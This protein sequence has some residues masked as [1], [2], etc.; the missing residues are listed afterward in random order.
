MAPAWWT[1]LEVRLKGVERGT[2]L[3]DTVKKLHD[4]KIFVPNLLKQLFT[5]E[6]CRDCPP[7]PAQSPQEH[8]HKAELEASYGD[9][10]IAASIFLFNKSLERTCPVL[11][12]R[13]N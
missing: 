13:S 2:S 11:F 3:L 9:P 12:A 6:P 10:V 5:A 7:A 1:N 8:Y 4:N